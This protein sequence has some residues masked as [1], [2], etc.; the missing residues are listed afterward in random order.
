MGQFKPITFPG[1][2]GPND[3]HPGLP[4]DVTDDVGQLH[5]HQ[6]QRFLHMLDVSAAIADQIIAMTNQGP[7]STDLF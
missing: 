4:R 7:Q 2:N 3:Q 6:L 1:H 5:I